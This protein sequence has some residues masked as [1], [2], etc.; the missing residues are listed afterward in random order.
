MNTRNN[1]CMITHDMDPLEVVE[2]I[3]SFLVNNGLPALVDV[4]DMD[5]PLDGVMF[6]DLEAEGAN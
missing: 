2:T 3:S 5:T 6:F 1:F 4:T